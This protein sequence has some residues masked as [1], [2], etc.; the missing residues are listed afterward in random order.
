MR[1]CALGQRMNGRARS[2]I[3]LVCFDVGGVLVDT[4]RTFLE[5]I[6]EA[7]LP[8]RSSPLEIDQLYDSALHV[9]QAYRTGKITS[10]QY[11]TGVSSA[12][13]GLYTKAEVLRIRDASIKGTYPETEA[14]LLKL[15]GT[16]GIQIAL[17]TNT[18]VEHWSRIAGLPWMKYVDHSFTSHE[19]GIAKPSPQVF[20][21]V[22]S[23]TRKLSGEILYFDDLESNIAAS[24]KLG[25]RSVLVVSCNN[26]GA[27]IRNEL[28]E[29]GILL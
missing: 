3:K 10:E 20:Q 25:W 24:A 2:S 21:A 5:G 22:K 18:N 19:M 28:S 17:L 23:A 27:Q 1:S 13:H 7:G 6:A 14:I 15:S 29:C 9:R 12:L 4:C 16:P 26:P 11:A 8:Y